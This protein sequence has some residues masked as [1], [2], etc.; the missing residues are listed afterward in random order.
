[1]LILPDAYADPPGFTLTTATY[2][3]PFNRP[4]LI[5][6][7]FRR[8]IVNGP[9]VVIGIAGRPPLTGADPW[10]IDTAWAAADTGPLMPTRDR[11]LSN[12]PPP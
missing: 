7:G 3:A 10:G 11:G 2:G 1:M 4:S 12:L 8:E 9:V 6:N 5:I